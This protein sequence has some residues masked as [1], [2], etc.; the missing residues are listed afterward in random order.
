MHPLLIGT[1][2]GAILVDFCEFSLHQICTQPK[3][4]PFLVIFLSTLLLH[5]PPNPVPQIPMPTY[6]QANQEI[7][8]SPS[9][10]DPY[11]TLG[12]LFVS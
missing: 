2:D 7:S 6:P 9:Q 4:H 12:V 8:F 3:K 1:L 5:S 11:V 10:R